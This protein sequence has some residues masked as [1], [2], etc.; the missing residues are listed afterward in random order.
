MNVAPTY[1]YAML[2][3]IVKHENSRGTLCDAKCNKFVPRHTC[4]HSSNPSKARR[5]LRVSCFKT[6]HCPRAPCVITYSP[7]LCPLQCRINAKLTHSPALAPGTKITT[8]LNVSAAAQVCDNGG[9]DRLFYGHFPQV[10]C[11][12][13]QSHTEHTRK[14]IF[15]QR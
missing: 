10:L 14:I 3:L 2:E 11:A 12:S 1:S 7:S 9:L 5:L 15:L 8:V 13:H 4:A 6:R